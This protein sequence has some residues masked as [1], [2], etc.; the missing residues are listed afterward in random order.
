[1]INRLIRDVRNQWLMLNNN[2]VDEADEVPQLDRKDSS[3][4]LEKSKGLI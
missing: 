3:L 1:M 2:Q 4:Q